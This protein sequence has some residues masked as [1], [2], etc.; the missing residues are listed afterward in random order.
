ML[1]WMDEAGVDRAVIVP[2]IW[3]GDGNESALEWAALHPGRLAVMG[4]FDLWD[5]D[6]SQLS[7]WL[8]QPGMLG[9]RMSYAPDLG[10]GWLDVE[11]MR[12]FWTE[13]DALGLPIMLLLPGGAPERSAA[14][15]EL[16]DTFPRVKWIIDHLGLRKPAPGGPASDA[17]AG[18]HHILALARHPNVYVKWSALPFYS[19]AEYPY[20]DLN[21]Y[22]RRAL[23]AFGARRTMWGSDLTRLRRLSYGQLA[24]HARLGMPFLSSEDREQILGKTAATVLG[25][26]V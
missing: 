4:R 8:D 13:A 26:P 19:A 17:F 3:A 5:P 21:P 11:Q 22:L 12:W 20:P 6:R 16:A 24:G 1:R 18:F 10:M 9:I 7:R 14:L 23:A 2:P 25:W 15:G